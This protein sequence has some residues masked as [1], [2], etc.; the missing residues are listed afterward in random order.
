[1]AVATPSAGPTAAGTH[2]RQHLLPDAAVVQAV[3][4]GV[5]HAG[6]EQEQCGGDL[7]RYWLIRFMN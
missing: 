1:M 7:R 5:E 6:G 4:D 3:H 2:A